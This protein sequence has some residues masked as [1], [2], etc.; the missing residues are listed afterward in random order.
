MQPRFIPQVRLNVILGFGLLLAGCAQFQHQ[1]GESEPHALVTVVKP[2]N[3][4]GPFGEVKSL[5]GLPVSAGQAYRVKPG[6]HTVVVQFVETVTETSQ[7]YTATLFH[8]GNAPPLEEQPANVHLSQTGGV[9]VT[10]QQPFATMQPANLSVEDRR[11]RTT[12]QSISVKAGWHYE[13]KGNLV[14]EKPSSVR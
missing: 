4:P 11:T 13:L 8:A 14:T 12:T 6:T 1:T 10:G 3:S 9:S 5:D 2:G 7:R